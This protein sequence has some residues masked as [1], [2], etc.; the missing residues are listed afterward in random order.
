MIAAAINTAPNASATDIRKCRRFD[1]QNR[2]EP[3]VQGGQAKLYCSGYCKR[4]WHRIRC[5]ALR[6]TF[7]PRCVAPRAALAFRPGT[8]PRNIAPRLVGRLIIL[9]SRRSR[10]GERARHPATTN[11]IS[12]ILRSRPAGSARKSTAATAASSNHAP[13]PSAPNAPHCPH[14][15]RCCDGSP[16]RRTDYEQ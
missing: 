3:K 2:F 7:G 5:E 1:C 11:E 10:R 14:R 6:H 16:V 9:P 15:W 4:R 12:P 13:R 8:Q